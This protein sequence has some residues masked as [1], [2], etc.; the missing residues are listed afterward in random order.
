MPPPPPPGALL[1]PLPLLP[2]C[3]RSPPAPCRELCTCAAIACRLGA[4]MQ[5]PEKYIGK[6]L[7]RF[8]VKVLKIRGNVSG[9]GG[10][11]QHAQP[12]GE[13]GSLAAAELALP[14]G[15]QT[16]S[17]LSAVTWRRALTPCVSRRVSR[18]PWRPPAGPNPAAEGHAGAPAAL[19]HRC[20]RQQGGPA[21][22]GPHRDRERGGGH[23]AGHEVGALCGAP[24][25]ECPLPS[26]HP[27]LSQ[28]PR[29]GVWRITLRVG[30]AEALLLPCPEW[31]WCVRQ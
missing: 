12:W 25:G 1:R 13:A 24:P 29:R 20:G 31:G 11:E 15:C 26:L 4:N 22:A 8:T 16:A 7:S 21:P 28:P 14:V 27:H 23:D 3:R 30:E 18:R 2:R 5:A 17:R 9:V 6:A 19:P 10:G